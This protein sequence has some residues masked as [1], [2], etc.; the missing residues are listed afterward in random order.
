ML[1]LPS[2]SGKIS[3]IHFSG[4]QNWRK[5]CLNHDKKISL[6]KYVNYENLQQKY[7][8]DEYLQQKYTNVENLQQ[9]CVNDENF[10]TKVLKW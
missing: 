8:Y 3:S 4:E 10:A 9:K 7:V 5:R 2:K 1:I 6:Q